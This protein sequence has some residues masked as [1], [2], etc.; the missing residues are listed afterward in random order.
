MEDFGS[1]FFVLLNFDVFTQTHGKEKGKSC[2]LGDGALQ[3]PKIPFLQ[4]WQ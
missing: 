2:E 4:F 3:W 1:L